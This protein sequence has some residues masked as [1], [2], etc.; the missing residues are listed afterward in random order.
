MKLVLFLSLLLHSASAWNMEGMESYFTSTH[1]VAVDTPLAM[2]EKV[3]YCYSDHAAPDTLITK[4]ASK[5]LAPFQSVR[6]VVSDKEPSQ[7]LYSADT[8]D[9]GEWLQQTHA[10]VSKIS[11]ANDDEACAEHADG[12]CYADTDEK[13]TQLQAEHPVTCVRLYTRISQRF[14]PPACALSRRARSTPPVTSTSD[15]I[16]KCSALTFHSGRSAP[17]RACLSSSRAARTS[18]IVTTLSAPPFVRRALAS[19]VVAMPPLWQRFTR[20]GST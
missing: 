10:K 6:W 20:R 8:N 16:R 4:V 15:A 11:N 1:D 19:K 13:M 18:R 14:S 5:L 7:Q 12:Q 17:P 3:F 2:K 9:F